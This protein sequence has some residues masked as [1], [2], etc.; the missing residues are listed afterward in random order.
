M[1]GYSFKR[2]QRERLAEGT[3][4]KLRKLQWKYRNSMYLVAGIL[5][6]YVIINSRGLDSLFSKFGAFG[7]FGALFSGLL[8]TFSLTMVPAA[9]ILYKLGKTLN[10]VLIG[11]FGAA[12]SVV[13]DY[14][15][16]KFVKDK[17]LEELKLLTEEIGD[18]IA[19]GRS[20]F[21]NSIFYRL[22]PFSNL[23]LSKN[24]RSTLVKMSH[25]RMWR[26]MLAIAACA[27]IALPLP[28]ELG[29]SLLGMIKFKT[30]YFILV[31][32]TFNFVGIVLISYLGATV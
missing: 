6:A 28:D 1:K 18:K 5:V 19:Y 8:Y 15:I 20:I 12:G 26:T 31:S 11:V 32:Y 30:K 13:S 17:L 2:R 9:A 16:F 27:I 21:K 29:V 23:L 4:G 10:P 3:I 7:Y 22:F 14:F 25:S 24:F